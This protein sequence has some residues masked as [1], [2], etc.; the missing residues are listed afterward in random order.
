MKSQ[1]QKKEKSSLS[2]QGK[3]KKKYGLVPDFN[4]GLCSCKPLILVLSV[5]RTWFLKV[6]CA[7]GQRYVTSLCQQSTY[8]TEQLNE[9]GKK[10]FILLIFLKIKY[11]NTLDVEDNL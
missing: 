4:P 2:L 1:P 8:K 5:F 6:G 11:N 7:Q 10:V 9:S 3:K